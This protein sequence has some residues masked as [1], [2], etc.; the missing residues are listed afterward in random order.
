MIEDQRFVVT[1]DGPAGVGKSSVANAVA[2]QLGAAFLDTGAMYRAV[3]LAAIGDGADLNDESVLLEILDSKNFSFDVADDG[4]TVAIDGVDVTEAIRDPNVTSNVRFIASAVK[5]RERLVDLQRAFA[6]EHERIVTEG[7]DQGTVAFADA[8]FKFF[9]TADVEERAKRRKL[10]L[11]AA[12]K[13]ADIN[14]L[15]EN[16]K[17]RDAGDEQREAGALAAAGDAVIVDTTGL[18]FEQVVE[19]LVE[20]IKNKN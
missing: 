1:I 3:T 19:K 11:E 4:M 2:K 5:V 7:R 13:K 16:I 20:E 12:G 15:I 9:L 6:C 10:Q 14:E 8:G 17:K 18:S